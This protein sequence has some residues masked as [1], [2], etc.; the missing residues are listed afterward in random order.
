ML[1]LIVDSH[2]HL[3]AHE[4]DDD[5]HEVIRRAFQE[6][7]GAI[8]C[9]A[10]LSEEKELEIALDITRTY[11]NIIAAAG[12]H[13]HNAKD[14]TADDLNKIELLAKGKNIRAVGEIGVDFHYNFSPPDVQVKVFKKQISMAQE[15][16]LPVVIH[17]RNASKEILK[18]VKEERFTRGGI[19]HCFTEDWEFAETMMGYNFLISFSGI[20][21]FPKAQSL[22]EVA[23][24]TPMEKI[25][26][27][28]DSPYL[29][30]VPYRGKIERNEPV[31]VKETA[32][33]LAKLKNVSL[34][35]LAE[36][37]TS[38]FESLFQ[39]EIQKPRC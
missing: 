5:R 18:A 12:V 19:I 14:F 17:S 21:T 23:I 39:I 9:P 24:R 34:E 3:T 1:R 10:D 38:N 35:R 15:M 28:T 11:T 31:Y 20:L 22:R 25:L 33:F 2:A 7:I 29:A 36:R 4:F 32:Q 8:L 16:G 30:P 26:V 27:E 37:T 13:P 6:G